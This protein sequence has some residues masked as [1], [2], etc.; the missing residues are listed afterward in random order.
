MPLSKRVRRVIGR[1]AGMP[2]GISALLLLRLTRRHAGVALMY[3]SVA[4]RAGDPDRELVP[5][6]ESG[7]FERQLRHL[8]RHY[9][10]VP[11]ARLQEAART[12]RRGQRFPVAI[13]FDDDLACHESVALPIL[14]RTGATAT[15]FL[16]GASLE[17]PFAFDYERLQRAV[18]ERVPAVPALVTGTP[19]ATEPSRIHELSL[20]LELMTPEDRDAAAA[21]LGD[22]VGPDPPDAGIRAEQ[23]RRLADA[24][25]TVGFHTYRHHSLTGLTDDQLAQAM[26]MGRDILAEAAGAPV[27]TIGYP[28]GRADERVAAAARA[29]GFRAGFTTR[30]VP[31]TPQSDPLLQ[32]RVGPSLHSVGGLA[33]EVVLTLLRWS[34]SARPSPAR[35]RPAS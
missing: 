12:R 28:H 26:D 21:R 24:G 18:D 11:A 19:G 6:H 23:V 25:M 2:L 35:Q 27:D 32:G 20:V 31:V 13:T 14:R 5:P 16:S 8:R 34:G 4:A 3:H 29:A 1:T 9:D 22:A 10:V 15:F 30:R 17:R 33:L 7:L